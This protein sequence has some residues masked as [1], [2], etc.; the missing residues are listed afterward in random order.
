MAEPVNIACTLAPG[1][2]AARTAEI[3]ALA[4]A[5]LRT[6]EPIAHGLRLTFDATAEDDLRALV[7]AEAACCPFLTLDLARDGKQLRLDVTG[8]D[9]AAPVIDAL[10]A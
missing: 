3:E 5:A 2:Y 7:A 6:R 4:R 10:F 1:D 8:P 9:D